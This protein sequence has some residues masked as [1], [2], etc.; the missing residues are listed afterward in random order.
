MDGDAR[1]PNFYSYREG[2]KDIPRSTSLKPA[3][4]NTVKLSLVGSCVALIRSL[5]TTTLL[6]SAP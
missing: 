5:M 2:V 6:G 1:R 4:S 3:E